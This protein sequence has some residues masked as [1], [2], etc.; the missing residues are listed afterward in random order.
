MNEQSA[1]NEKI[2]VYGNGL[3]LRDWIYVEDNVRAI[4]LILH[5][6]KVGE[7][8]NIS[9]HQELS[10]IELVR[11]IIKKMKKDESLI[12]FVSDRLAHDKRYLISNDK[13]KTL[14]WTAKTNFD[15]GLDKVIKHYLD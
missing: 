15:E 1:E 13:I 5:K 3:N 9:N 6:G 2:P 8:Y 10:N 7:I 14:G 4:D 11:T 12:E